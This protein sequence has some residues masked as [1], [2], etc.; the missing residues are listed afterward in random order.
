MNEQGQSNGFGFVN[1][2]EEEA[3]NEAIQK[4]DGMLMADMKVSVA[5]FVPKKDR[6]NLGASQTTFTNVYV[7]NFPE[8]FS[9]ESV[10]SLFS[11]FGAI[12]S[13]YYNRSKN[14]LPFAC[15]NFGTNEAAVAVC[16]CMECKY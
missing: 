14:N 4:V 5:K 16:V 15:I 9:E 12:T 7:N 11:T 13:L 6:N 3:A 2:A 10:K 1:F 8:N